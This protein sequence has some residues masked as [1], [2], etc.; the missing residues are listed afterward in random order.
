MSANS[1]K[2]TVVSR[3]ELRM[4]FQYSR[5]FAATIKTVKDNL[6]QR[7]SNRKTL[8]LK[9]IFYI[10]ILLEITFITILLRIR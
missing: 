2:K 9:E 4:F 10:F 6:A 5:T 8:K 7:R 3:C 1:N